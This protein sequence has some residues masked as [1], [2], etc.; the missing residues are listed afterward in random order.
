MSIDRKMMLAALVVVGG[1]LGVLAYTGIGTALASGLWGAVSQN[2]ALSIMIGALLLLIGSAL[3]CVLYGFGSD[4][5]MS[6]YRKTH[7]A[8]P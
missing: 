3:G 4:A 5:R 1:I 8:R 7:R 6:G 2:V